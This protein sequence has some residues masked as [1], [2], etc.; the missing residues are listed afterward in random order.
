ML[1][2]MATSRGET[3]AH[4]RPFQRFLFGDGPE[5]RQPSETIAS[6]CTS[7]RTAVE[8]LRPPVKAHGGKYYLA[9]QIVPILLDVRAR[10]DEYLEPCAFGASVYLAMPK[11]QREIL[12]DVNPDVVNLWTT[13]GDEQLAAELTERLAAIPYSRP[14]F[15]AAQQETGG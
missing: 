2:P 8:R 13:L 1:S 5:G 6:I 14:V 11:M 9:R 7:T 12:G 15:E 10:I 4:D 3:G